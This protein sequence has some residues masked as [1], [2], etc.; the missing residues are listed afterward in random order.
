MCD[1]QNLEVNTP[2]ADFFETE[3]LGAIYKKV[4]ET[5]GHAP[6]VGNPSDSTKG[7]GSMLAS[8][9]ATLRD[10][11]MGSGA[12]GCYIYIFFFVQLY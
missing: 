6:L 8:F 7:C 5:D 11:D 3:N 1:P 4:R 2:I 10:E 9:S 12:V